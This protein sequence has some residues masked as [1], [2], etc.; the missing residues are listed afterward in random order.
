MVRVR[1]MFSFYVCMLLVR[2]NLLLILNEKNFLF[3]IINVGMAR[4]VHL[5]HV[6]KDAFLKG[7]VEPDFDEQDL[8]FDASPIYVELLEQVRKE[9]NW[10]GPSDVVMLEGR[11]NV[12]FGHHIRWK[13]MGINSEQRWLAY[14]WWPNPKTRLLKYL[15]PK[16]A[17]H[18]WTK[19]N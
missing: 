14:K 6:N 12:G 11:H 13:T 3:P 18:P 8:V 7:N 2:F 9:L 5:H 16:G 10:M 19:R 4:I 15:P 17:L 1:D